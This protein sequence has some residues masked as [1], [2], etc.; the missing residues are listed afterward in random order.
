MSERN[1]NFNKPLANLDFYDDSHG[2]ES[3]KEIETRYGLENE[4][5]RAV[6]RGSYKK[7]SK[8]FTA[9]DFARGIEKRVDD[10][11]RNMK[12]YMIILNTL[13]RKG[14]EVGNVHP[15]YIHGVSSEFAMRIENSKTEKDIEK[16]WDDMIYS[17][18]RLVKT[19][20]A[21]GYSPLVQNVV[22]LIDADLNSDLTLNAMAKRFNVNASYLS[23]LFKKD[24]GMPLTE[25]VS[26]KRVERA[27]RLLET[28]SH[29]I[30]QISHECGI[31][32]VNYFA[33]IFKKHTGETPKQY[34]ENF[35]AEN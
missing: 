27:K 31:L 11:V 30:Q 7:L 2:N 26:K 4:M 6:S 18:C 9:N 12:N 10:P 5:I 33:K 32:D 19:H 21:K 16:L 14:A 28:T 1:H 3:I 29:Q 17:Y 15:F 25:Y 8:L 35:R 24:T 20:A 34:R 23:S 13:L 22:M